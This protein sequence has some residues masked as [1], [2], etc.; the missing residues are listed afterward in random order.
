[1]SRRTL[2]PFLPFL[3]IL[4]LIPIVPTQVD[5]Q[6]T[7]PDLE[8]FSWRGIGPFSFSGRASA[9]AVPEG[10]SKVMYIGMGTGGLWKT[11]DRGL[12]WTPIFDQYGTMSMGWIEIAPSDHNIIYL[13]TGE[14]MHARSSTHGNGVWK[15]T[16]AGETWTNIGLTMSYY[17]PRI[18]VHPSNPDIVYVAAE[19]KLYNNDMDSERGLYK[20]TDGG[21]NWQLVLDLEDRGVGD[22]VMDPTNP[23]VLIAYGYRTF[24]RTWTFIDRQP[25]NA[26]YKTTDGGQNW[27]KLT[28]GLP[29]DIEMGR[30]G[31]AMYPKDPNIVYARLDEEVNLGL[32]TNQ[33]ATNFNARRG[34]FR[35]DFSFSGWAGFT[36]NRNLSRL[37]RHDKIQATDENDLVE[38]LNALVNDENFL[39]DARVD[40]DRFITAARGAFSGDQD[41]LDSIDEIERFRAAGSEA[42]AVLN[43]FVLQTLCAP[44]LAIQEPTTRDGAIYR[45]NDQGETWTRMTDYSQP[46]SGVI[47]QT[48]AGYYGRI[49]VDPNNPDWLYICNTNIMRSEDGGV[50]A[51][52]LPWSRRGLNHVD[53]RTLWIDPADSDHIISGNDGYASETWDGGDHWKQ[54]D[55]ISGQQ[56]YDVFVD[57]LQP[58]NVMGGTQDNGAWMGPS[59]TN[60][61]YGVFPSDWRYLPTGDGFYVV[62][63]WWNPE[64]VYY[65][66]QFGSSSAMNLKTGESWSLGRGISR[67]L[68]EGLD[69]NRF[70]WDAPIVLSP[71]NPGIVYITS[72]YVWRSYDHGRQDTWQRVS[73]DLT[74]SDPQ[75]IAQSRLTNLQYPTIYTFA[76]SSIKPGLFWAGTDDGNLQVSENGGASWRNVTFEFWNE[77]G[78]PRRNTQGARIP[79]DHWV[80]RVV[81]SAH[82]INT[83][84]VAFNGY[85]THAE[86][87]SYIFVTKDLG[88]TWQDISGGMMNPVNDL[89]ED[90]DNP[91]VLYIGTD[92]GLFVSVDAGGSWVEVS[93]AAPD[94][95]LL[96]MD[97]QERDRDLAL[98]SYGRGFFI[99]DIWPFKEFTQENLDQDAFMFDVQPAVQWQ[100][101]ENMGPTYGEMPVVPNPPA[102]ANLYYWLKGEANQVQLVV[103]DLEGQELRTLTGESGKGI[104]VVS[105]NL[106]GGSGGRG[107]FGGGGGGRGGAAGPSGGPGTYKVTLRVDG[108]DVMTVKFDVL[109][110]PKYGG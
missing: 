9:I 2:R 19:G 75:R 6:L 83:C 64:Y 61:G 53:T 89:E 15:S 68:L 34:L 86:D 59:R 8:V 88:R 21:Q 36:I 5:A 3:L 80:Q 23:D 107:G 66:S 43:R 54:W 37:V 92:Y 94:V 33:Q 31:L 84:Y 109:P 20:S 40:L 35:D 4:L 13:G 50:T 81:P 78:T 97:I 30:A 44:A 70:Q 104:H 60:N 62:R 10:Q 98:A 29:T 24:R 71:H 51:Q 72:Q 57:D 38:Q 105:W 42:P 76:E 11:E 90:P 99:V 85:R 39:S 102:G 65:E 49:E 47:N 103:T 73:P 46:R 32:G 110:D 91:N 7:T 108:E 100:M 55:L 56:F 74:R 82:D 63:D 67:D 22:F 1:M 12:S 106:R 14:V 27:Q 25:G 101:V 28:N 69:A 87:T 93:D 41:V 45:S 52:S 96:D 58:Y 18:E 48:E 77:D 26:L 16:D 95:I 17:I 79:F